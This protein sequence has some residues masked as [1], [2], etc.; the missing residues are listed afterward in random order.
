MVYLIFFFIHW[1]DMCSRPILQK[2]LQQ[3]PSK[4]YC[5]DTVRQN[6]NHTKNPMGNII[7]SIW[8]TAENSPAVWAVLFPKQTIYGHRNL[9]VTIWELHVTIF[10]EKLILE[11]LLLDHSCA[12]TFFT[13]GYNYIFPFA[14]WRFKTKL[15]VNPEHDFQKKKELLY[16]KNVTEFNIKKISPK[17]QP[18]TDIYDTGILQ[19]I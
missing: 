3:K 10:Q 7:M 15:N 14:C 12:L 19:N 8:S 4:I 13:L 6:F 9:L 11:S 2:C 17:I 5:Q 1:I 16:L 18:D